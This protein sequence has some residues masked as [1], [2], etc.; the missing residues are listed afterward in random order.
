MNRL[1]VT[2]SRKHRDREFIY[3]IL[4]PFRL[5]LWPNNLMIIEGGAKGADRICREW[6][7]QYG[8]PFKTF[9]ADWD[10]YGKAAGGIRN[11]EMVEYGAD[12]CVGFP[13]PSSVGTYDCASKARAAGIL[14]TMHKRTKRRDKAN[15]WEQLT[16]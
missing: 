7:E 2:G 5:L 15:G 1:L 9:E 16:F 11:T 8:I 14:T 10:R 6:A 12:R 4:D 13:L 3:S